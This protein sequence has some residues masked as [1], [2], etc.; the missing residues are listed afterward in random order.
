ML[1]QQPL[2]QALG[3]TWWLEVFTALTP[4]AHAAVCNDLVAY[5]NQ[6]EDRYSRFKSDSWVGQLNRERVLMHPDPEFTALLVRGQQ[7]YQQTDGVFNML[8]GTH[9]ENRG[10]NKDYTFTPVP[11]PT[12]TPNPTSDIHISPERITLDQGAV[13]LGGFG[14]GYLIDLLAQRLVE[15]HSCPAFLINGGGDIYATENPHEPITIYLEHP[16]KAGHFLGQTTLTH[17]AFAASSPHRRSWTHRDTMYTH[18]VDVSPQMSTEPTRPDATFIKHSSTATADAFATTLLLTT[19]AGRQTLIEN[20]NLAVV[21]YQ[22]ETNHL[23]QSPAFR[24]LSLY[25]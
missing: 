8:L 2:C 18:L 5:I 6:F 10:Y 22:T 14:K 25:S 24:P 1:D 21:T 17:E 16:R 19:G 7:L 4:A 12:H 3:T 15:R 20:N 13:D 9:L 23:F 11:E